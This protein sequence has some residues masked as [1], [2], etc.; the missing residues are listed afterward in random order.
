MKNICVGFDGVLARYDGWKGVTHIGKPIRGAQ[1][2][3]KG[4]SR[5]YRVIILTTRVNADVN[6]GATESELVEMIQLWMHENDFLPCEIWTAK[7]KPIAVA[8]ID[9]K[10]VCCRPQ[11]DDESFLDVLKVV[12]DLE[13]DNA[14]D[15]AVV[16]RDADEIQT[17]IREAEHKRRSLR[18]PRRAIGPQRS[19]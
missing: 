2:F 8:Y 9:D 11:K 13:N 12:R 1:K 10:S 4:L 17:R 5:V 7:A 16:I 15:D 18:D 3:V 14:E 19:R 6:R